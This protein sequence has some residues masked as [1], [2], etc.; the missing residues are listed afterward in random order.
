MCIIFHTL[1]LVPKTKVLEQPH[2]LYA[3][4]FI[5]A[6]CQKNETM[7]VFI[8]GDKKMAIIDTD[9]LDFLKNENEQIVLAELE[10][11]LQN[12]PKYIC[13]CKECLLDIMALALNSIMPLYRVTLVGKIYTGMAM[14][15]GEYA[16]VISDAVSKAIT[17]VYKNP[18]HPPRDE[19]E[20]EEKNTPYRFYKE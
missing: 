10:R 20:E 2:F 18:S 17:K 1:E 12:I 4:D 16:A 6:H 3:G 19:N 15:D 11:Q 5:S 14:A 9:D 13:T 8:N 7:V